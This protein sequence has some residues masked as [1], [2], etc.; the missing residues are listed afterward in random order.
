MALQQEYQNGLDKMNSIIFGKSSR[1]DIDRLLRESR[2]L[3]SAGALLA[4]EGNNW[5]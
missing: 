1:T 5:L 3:A 2:Q 4:I